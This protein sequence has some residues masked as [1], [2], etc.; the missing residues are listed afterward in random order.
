MPGT[1]DFHSI[2]EVK[3]PLL[4]RAYHN[5]STC[6]AG[7]KI[8]AAGESGLGKN[9]YRLYRESDKR[10]GPEKQRQGAGATGSKIKKAA[11]LGVAFY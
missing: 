9:N 10:N 6:L 2:N 7:R 11:S 8:K 3:K 1:A 5:N 4:N